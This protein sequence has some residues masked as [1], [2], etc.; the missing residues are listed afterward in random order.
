LRRRGIGDST[1]A[2]VLAVHRLVDAARFGG[3]MP[4]RARVVAVA[5]AVARR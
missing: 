4:E 5:E 3:P 2:E 1:I